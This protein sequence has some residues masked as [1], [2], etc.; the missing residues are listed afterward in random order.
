M[1]KKCLALGGGALHLARERGRL[2][3]VQ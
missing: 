1:F 2:G 3:G